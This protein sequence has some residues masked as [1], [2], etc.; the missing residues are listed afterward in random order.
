MKTQT[1]AGRQAPR[2]VQCDELWREACR[3]PRGTA[4]PREVQ[5]AVGDPELRERRV[6]RTGSGYLLL[7][8]PGRSNDCH[9]S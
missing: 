6:Q 3:G 5:G 1:R 9:D 4:S 8:E 2:A 7:S